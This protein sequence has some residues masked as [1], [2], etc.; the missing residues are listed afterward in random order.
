MDTRRVGDWK[1]VKLI[2]EFLPRFVILTPLTVMPLFQGFLL[3]HFTD[4]VVGR[5]KIVVLI[6]VIILPWVDRE[7]R[8]F[9]QR[10]Y[11]L[12]FFKLLLS[13]Q[14]LLLLDVVVDFDGCRPFIRRVLC[15]VKL[16]VVRVHGVLISLPDRIVLLHV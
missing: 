15:W 12:Y 5:L 2:Q 4:A 14:F 7:L 11:L 8:T 16:L 9:V 1:R 3:I 10:D 6:F 13:L